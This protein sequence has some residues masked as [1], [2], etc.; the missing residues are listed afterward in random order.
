[1]HLQTLRLLNSLSVLIVED[2]DIARATIKQDIKPYCKAFYEAS[3]G[4]EGLELFK[5]KPN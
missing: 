3:N 4:L 5:K 1:M 2:D